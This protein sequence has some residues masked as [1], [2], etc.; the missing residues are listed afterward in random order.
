MHKIYFERRCIII[1]SPSEEALQDPNCV[2]FHI[3]EKL[4]IHDLVCMFEVQ[5]TLSRIYIASDDIER[6]TAASVRNS[7]R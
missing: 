3:G 1:C 7:R 2:Q 5:D 4:D 6:R